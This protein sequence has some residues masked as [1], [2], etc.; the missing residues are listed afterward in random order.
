MFGLNQVGGTKVSINHLHTLPIGKVRKVIDWGGK[1]G[2][3]AHGT[4]WKVTGA[5]FNPVP[6]DVVRVINH[7]SG[8]T[9]LVEAVI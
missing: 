6:G 4:A 3:E 9:L 7:H 1:P 5:G 2:I 8:T